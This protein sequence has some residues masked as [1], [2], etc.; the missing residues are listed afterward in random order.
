M[1]APTP[2]PKGGAPDVAGTLAAAGTARKARRRIGWLVW[3][4]VAA[5]LL[6]AGAYWWT[7]R[8]AAATVYATEPVTRGALTV[9]VTATGSLYPTNQ[10]E[11]SSELSGTVRQ[12][13]VDYND[14]VKKGQELAELD[15]DKLSAAVEGERAHLAS[16]NAGVAEAKATITETKADLDRKTTLLAR[17]VGTQQEVEAA[18]AAHDRAV[19]ALASAEAAVKVADADLH[20]AEVNLEKACICSP[21]DGVVLSRDVEPGQTVAASFQAPVLFTI[22][23]DLKRME[24]RV[25][26]DEADV[27]GVEVGQQATFTVDAY[28]GRSFPARIRV[29]RYASET[30]DGVVTYKA[31]LDVDNADLALRPGMTATAEIVVQH[32]TDALLVPNQALRWAPPAQQEKSGG[33]SLFMMFPRPPRDTRP[34]PD[35]AGRRTVYVLRDGHPVAV[36]VEVGSSDGDRTVVTGDL[37]EGDAVIVDDTTAK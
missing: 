15:T 36:P 10:V 33:R 4:V 34:K 16:A 9:S 24:L 29:V 11:I 12:V 28:P 18:A 14:P 7:G 23:E 27:G 1:N 37:A 3:A 19:A 6:G 31:I 5:A 17:H 22:A 35:E 20:L 30:V 21:I 13:L 25:D 2:P 26:V 8:G 32:V